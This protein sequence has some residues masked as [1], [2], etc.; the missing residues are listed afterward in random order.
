MTFDTWY[1]KLKSQKCLNCTYVSFYLLAY[2]DPDLVAMKL[3]QNKLNNTFC[4][5]QRVSFGHKSRDFSAHPFQLP[6]NRNGFASIKIIKSKRHAKKRYIG[7]F[8]YMSL[9]AHPFQWP[10]RPKLYGWVGGGGGGFGQ[11]P[12][13]NPKR[14]HGSTNQAM[15]SLRHAA[16]DG[17]QPLTGASAVVRQCRRHGPSI[18]YKITPC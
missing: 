9:R 17:N 7:N 3:A 14:R 13:L 6:E 16:H 11:G 10:S 18:T 12:H 1:C 5:V 2:S 4:T 8:M 15:P